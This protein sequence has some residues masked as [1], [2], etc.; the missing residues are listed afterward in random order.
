VKPH[1][2]ISTV[3]KYPRLGHSICIQKPKFALC[4]LPQANFLPRTVSHGSTS[5]WPLRAGI[6]STNLEVDRMLVQ[7]PVCRDQSSQGVQSYVQADRKSSSF[8]HKPETSQKIRQLI[9]KGYGR[10]SDRKQSFSNA[11][12]LC[13]LWSKGMTTVMCFMSKAN[14]KTCGVLILR[15]CLSSHISVSTIERS[16]IQ[17]AHFQ[18]ASLI[19]MCTRSFGDDPKVSMSG[20]CAARQADVSIMHKIFAFKRHTVPS[21]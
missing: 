20:V 4:G 6:G 19:L 2:D 14:N 12:N 16:G 8:R 10:I 15:L 9:L 17:S 5:N 21:S 11:A 1:A 3:S 7:L 18:F 13:H